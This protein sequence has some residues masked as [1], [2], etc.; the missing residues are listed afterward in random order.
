[1]CETSGEEMCE[2]S[3]EVDCWMNDKIIGV[4]TG[5]PPGSSLN[6]HLAENC[7]GPLTRKYH[8]ESKCDITTGYDR[9]Y[10]WESNEQVSNKTSYQNRNG[11]YQLE[12]V[13][14]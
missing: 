11:W 2:T 13:L 8:W 4:P 10:H 9:N 6:D 14:D 3:G 5:R 1:M 7:D 12:K